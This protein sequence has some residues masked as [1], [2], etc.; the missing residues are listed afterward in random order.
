MERKFNP[1]EKNLFMSLEDILIIEDTP[2]S[3]QYS[4][5]N[6]EKAIK[7]SGAHIDGRLS[8]LLPNQI[9]FNED[10]RTYIALLSE[11]TAVVN[12]F[13]N[14]KHASVYISTCGS[15][16]PINSI[17]AFIYLFRPR[18]AKV[19]VFTSSSLDSA[20]KGYLT[21]NEEIFW[22]EFDEQKV[23]Y[24]Y[25]AKNKERERNGIYF[26][27]ISQCALQKPKRMIG[28]CDNEIDVMVS[29]YGVKKDEIIKFYQTF[30]KENLERIITVDG[31]E[32]VGLMA[33]A[34]PPLAR[35]ER[36]SGFSYIAE[37]KEGAFA[38][39]ITPEQNYVSFYYSLFSEK[40]PYKAVNKILEI[41][42]PAYVEAR[43]FGTKQI[44][45]INRKE[46]SPEYVVRNAEKYHKEFYIDLL[47]K[48]E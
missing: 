40:V 2:I 16:N 45:Q 14:K 35:E 8:N 22:Q 17:E 13:P 34:F 43:V 44:K 29:M 7:E 6:I 25:E 26:D 30:S 23:P 21:T 41:F 28:P 11:S 46:L 18:T 12:I 38:I 20:F 15:P 9:G 24:F 37:L 3:A 27:L 5:D 19:R 32:L 31:K 47:R 39:H 10:K 42:L 1:V 48:G 4:V 36:L 33:K